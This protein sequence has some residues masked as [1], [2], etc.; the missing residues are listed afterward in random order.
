MA[1]P[2]LSFTRTRR[3]VA[4]LICLCDSYYALL[5]LQVIASFKDYIRHRLEH[6]NVVSGLRAAD[7]PAI[8]AWETG[9]ELSAPA[10]WTADIAGGGDGGR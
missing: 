8:M 1:W 7:D 6:V 10:N 4:L 3:W 9:N 5:R 2:R